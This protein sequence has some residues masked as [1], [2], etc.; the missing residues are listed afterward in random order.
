MSKK[1][2]IAL[3]LMGLCALVLVINTRSTILDREV[4]VYLLVTTV[5]ML[6]SL[7]FLLFLSVGVAIGVLL[8]K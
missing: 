6:K 8:H 4:S 3:V 5:T 7:A 1:M 2:L